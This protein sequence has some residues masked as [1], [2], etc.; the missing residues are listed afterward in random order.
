ML[1]ACY[2]KLLTNFESDE[3]YQ[4]YEIVFS[5]NVSL[6]L[7]QSESAAFKQFLEK[8]SQPS[9]IQPVSQ[10]SLVMR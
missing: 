4:V 2:W 7:S 3:T 10:A 1:Q 5:G 6:V 9:L 8:T